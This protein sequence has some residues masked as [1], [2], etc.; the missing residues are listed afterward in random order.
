MSSSEATTYVMTITDKQMENAEN[1]LQ[2][3]VLAW[4]D[5]AMNNDNN[6]FNVSLGLL[7]A[8]QQVSTF[9]NVQKCLEYLS[10][11]TEKRAFLIL[12]CKI[13]QNL[14]DDFIALS[15][16]EYIYT[17]GDET[18]LKNE[19]SKLVEVTSIQSL[20]SHLSRNSRLNTEEENDTDFA[21]LTSETTV[22]SIQDFNGD[23]RIFIFYQL[24]IEI[25]LRLPKTP[26]VREQFFSFC[27]EKTNDNLAQQKIFQKRMENYKPDQAILWYTDTSF[28]H[29]LL[30]RT[31]R[32]GNIIDMFK[33]A[34]FMVDLN[35]Q[36]KIVHH[37]YFDSYTEQVHVYRGRPMSTVE[38]SKL[39]NSIGDL[40]VTKSFLSTTTKR[41]V[42]CF[43]SG[44]GTQKPD[45]VPAILHMIINKQRNETKSFARVRYDSQVSEDD[46]VLI[47]IGT[48]F[49]VT[50]QNQEVIIHII[51]VHIFS[52]PFL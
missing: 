42:A 50:K 27:M 47:S 26:E 21:S 41:D 19:Q 38:F 28:L 12:S 10:S 15:Q 2:E 24:L 4:L 45:F 8:I 23:A 14:L 16:L 33:L 17:F 32:L 34:F 9:K 46:E 48:I 43:Y 1:Y 44:V 29:K 40:V 13:D 20:Y 5:T 30:N 22:K 49:R 6:K 7:R 51:A 31:C 25:L 3:Y 37:K 11:I 35:A 36:L 39:Q 52:P 18:I